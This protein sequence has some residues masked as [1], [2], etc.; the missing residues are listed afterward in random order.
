MSVSC[1]YS[2]P[3]ASARLNVNQVNG[4]VVHGPVGIPALLRPAYYGEAPIAASA[5][6]GR[7]YVDYAMKLEERGE[8]TLHIDE[9]IEGWARG[10]FIDNFRRLALV[11]VGTSFE[12]REIN[13]VVADQSPSLVQRLGNT[14]VVNRAYFDLMEFYHG[15]EAVFSRGD[16]QL[17]YPEFA[18]LLGFQDNFDDHWP[19][20]FWLPGRTQQIHR[21]TLNQALQITVLPLLAS[22]L[23]DDISLAHYLETV[24]QL[25]AVFNAEEREMSGWEN[26]GRGYYQSISRAQAMEILEDEALLEEFFEE[27]GDNRVVMKPDYNY[28]VVRA[29]MGEEKADALGILINR[30]YDGFPRFGVDDAARLMRVLWEHVGGMFFDLDLIVQLSAPPRSRQL[31]MYEFWNSGRNHEESFAHRKK[32]T[33]NGRPNGRYVLNNWLQ[34]EQLLLRP[35]VTPGYKKLLAVFS[36]LTVARF[37]H[38]NAQMSLYGEERDSPQAVNLERLIDNL[39][40]RFE[41]ADIHNAVLA[42]LRGYEANEGQRGGQSFD[43]ARHSAESRY[44]LARPFR[45]LWVGD[46]HVLWGQ[47]LADEETRCFIEELNY[48]MPYFDLLLGLH[49]N[50]IDGHRY[51]RDSETGWLLDSKHSFYCWIEKS[52][53]PEQIT[54]AKERCRVDV[55]EVVIANYDG[56][57]LLDSQPLFFDYDFMRIIA[58]KDPELFDKIIGYLI[59]T[60]ESEYRTGAVINTLELIEQAYPEIFELIGAT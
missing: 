50:E 17:A 5:L 18:T 36:Q 3:Q 25:M 54:E 39:Y 9:E 51:K 4:S 10:L 16:F 53:K 1:F 11:N 14:F 52:I 40:D 13:I 44:H 15:E 47:W 49:T 23:S 59:H 37:G 30:A 32:T 42:A 6:E 58:E 33:I 48:P 56:M 29:R 45:I 20:P 35:E 43:L 22:V 12:A 8:V 21:F 38:V 26:K 28:L 7:S 46:A 55:A 24:Q 60:T 2:S 31:S 27:C 19:A 57:Q 41:R 34:E